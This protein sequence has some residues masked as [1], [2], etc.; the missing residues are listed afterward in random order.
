MIN[1]QKNQY[2]YSNRTIKDMSPY[3]SR[4]VN[5][6]V[7]WTKLFQWKKVCQNTNCGQRELTCYIN[8]RQNKIKL[9]S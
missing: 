1:G 9:S 7:K 6:N 8:I 5:L 3:S 4:M 2:K